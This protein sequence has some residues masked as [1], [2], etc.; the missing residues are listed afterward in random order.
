MHYINF[1]CSEEAAVANAEYHY[2]ASPNSLV[3]NNADYAEYMSSV[4][5]EAMQY[6]YYSM[7]DVETSSYRN[8]TPERLVMLNSLW[9]ELKVESTIGDGIYICCGVILAALILLI[10]LNFLRKR[11]WAK[12]YD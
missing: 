1:L 12:L 9:E 4:H 8:L 11:R 6:L 5:E 10:V 7:N 3:I 2:Y